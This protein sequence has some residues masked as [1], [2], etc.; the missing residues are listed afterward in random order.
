[1]EPSFTK[2]RG[3]YRRKKIVK[4]RKSKNFGR[5]SYFCSTY[6]NIISDWSIN[7]KTHLWV[8]TPPPLPEGKGEEIPKMKKTSRGNAS[9]NMYAKF[10]DDRT[11]FRH[12]KI[13]GTESGTYIQTDIQN[14]FLL[15]FW[16]CGRLVSSQKKY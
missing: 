3:I 8:G 10:C 6:S 15:L 4:I 13:G 5:F 7:S 16:G 14:F 9:R 11:I 12:L 2:I 1:M